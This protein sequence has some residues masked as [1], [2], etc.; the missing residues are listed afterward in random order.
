MNW[1]I[2]YQK[3]IDGSLFENVNIRDN[4][5]RIMKSNK[6]HHLVECLAKTTKETETRREESGFHKTIATTY[7]KWQEPEAIIRVK[8]CFEMG[9]YKL[10]GV[11]E[12]DNFF[13]F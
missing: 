3:A 7:L 12:L 6:T 2:G 13:K 5:F 10:T 4:R 11:E 8:R 9:E 1:E